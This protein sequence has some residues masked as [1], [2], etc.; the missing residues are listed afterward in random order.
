MSE[1][2]GENARGTGSTGEAHA[3]APHPPP[4]S[5]APVH[6]P[7]IMGRTARRPVAEQKEDTAS[8]KSDQTKKK[9]TMSAPYMVDQE[10][11]PL[12]DPAITQRWMDKFA[13]DT[14]GK[15]VAEYVW[16]DGTGEMLRC[17]ARTMPKTGK[18]PKL[19]D[20]ALWQFDGSSTG[21]APGYDSEVTLVPRAMFRDPFRGPADVIV[22]CDCYEPAKVMSDGSVQKMR[23]I[24]SNTRAPC[25]EVMKKVAAEEPWFGIEQ[26]YTLLNATT[27]W[28]LGW[29]KNGYPAPQGPYYCSVGS[30]VAIARDVCEVHYRACMYAGLNIS[31]INGEV[32]PSQWEYQIGP[33]TGID[34]GDHMWMSRFIMHKVC[35]IFGVECTFDPKPIP[36]DWNG[37]GGH[38]NFSTK[39]TRTPPNGWKVIQEHCE[40]LRKRHHTHIINYGA[41]NEKRLTG[42]HETSGM[43]DF[44]WGVADRGCSIRVGRNIPIE[45][46]GY[47]EDRRPASNLDPYVVCR[48]MCE[49]TLL[50]VTEDE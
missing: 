39:S 35:E 33:C 14:S 12:L 7:K 8:V 15:F 1:R 38:C 27:K 22:L 5:H 17:K 37:S 43:D 45:K 24:P 28:P 40:K 13:T 34:A 10:I 20:M 47:Y 21:Q 29:P 3:R 31:G 48:L 42:T 32:L 16:I 44:S 6:L 30:G 4:P 36:G 46:C 9:S 23:P 49:T 41:G 25:A 50:D 26:E 18:A 11:R 19:S 2:R